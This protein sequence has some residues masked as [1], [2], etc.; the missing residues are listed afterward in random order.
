[1]PLEYCISM[2]FPE[3]FVVAPESVSRQ[4]RGL[5]LAGSEL[6][7]PNTRTPK[8]HERIKNNAFSGEPSLELPMSAEPSVFD[9][10]ILSARLVD[11]EAAFIG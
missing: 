10:E 6:D 3:I 9:F 1:M 5:H 8:K 2:I 4:G 7:V 11:T